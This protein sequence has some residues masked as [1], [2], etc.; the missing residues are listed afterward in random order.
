MN[1]FIFGLGQSS[2]SHVRSLLNFSSISKI[3][4]FTKY[5]A[6]INHVK[7]VCIHRDDFELVSKDHPPD[8]F[9]IASSTSTHLTDYELICDFNVPIVFEK[10]ISSSLTDTRKVIDNSNCMAGPYVFFQ[11]RLSPE[12]QALL[13]LSR[14]NAFKNP[15][16]VLCHLSK[17][18]SKS[19][20]GYLSHYGI[21]YI[22]LIFRL[23]NVHDY[24][25]SSF[26][27]DSPG[28]EKVA[29]VSGLFNH[30]TYFS[31]LLDCCSRFSCGSSISIQYDNASI[32]I[33][34][35][36]VSLVADRSLTAMY[37]KLLVSNRNLLTM[38]ITNMADYS[39]FWSYFFCKEK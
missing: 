26:L 28:L 34:D 3:F 1:V 36:E 5:P 10:P 31:V 21:H 18:K 33:K 9:L 27:G 2:K 15:N 11:R 22:D 4:I 12:F 17:Y 25:I 37:D 39:N 30:N 19:G 14:S 35:H 38:N 6:Q 8:L 24:K 32:L 20:F 7:V 23:L 13:T 29:S 16:S